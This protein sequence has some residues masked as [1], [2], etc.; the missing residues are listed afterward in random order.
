MEDIRINKKKMKA[1]I[2]IMTSIIP[3]SIIFNI[4]MLFFR[5]AISVELII[6]H[7]LKKIGIGVLEAEKIPNPLHLPE[8]INQ[9]F[10][11]AS[12]LFF[13]VFIMVG[14]FTRFAVLPVLAVTLTGYFLQHWN[15]T[16]LEKDM[17]FMYSVSCLLILFLGPGKYSFDYLSNKKINS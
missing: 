14:L 8:A 4:A 5:V 6:A 15:D 16:L 12:N 11:I 13:P 17:P 10:A 1:I 2:K 3:L 9:S 7:G